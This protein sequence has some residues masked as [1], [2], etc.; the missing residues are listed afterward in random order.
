MKNI[1]DNISFILFLLS[2][3]LGSLYMSWRDLVNFWCKVEK[4]L[5]GSL[6]SIPSP[7]PTVKIQIIGRK[8]CLKCK[9]KTLL[10]VVN[11]VLPYYLK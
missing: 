11:N 1:F 4:I 9:G 2:P 6:D 7:S 8:V 5:E 3:T 10:S